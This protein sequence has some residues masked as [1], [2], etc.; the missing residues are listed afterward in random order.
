[1]DRKLIFLDIDGTLITAMSEP[2]ALTVKAVRRVRENGH[3]VFLCT[4]RNMAIIGRDILD[5][6]FDGII[7]SAGSHVE[8]GGEVL[9]D[10]LLTEET[11]QECLSVFHS[12]GI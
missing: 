9:F 6:G 12:H 1:M 3:K 11:V 7:S 10:S 4:G 8:V 2:S 5:V